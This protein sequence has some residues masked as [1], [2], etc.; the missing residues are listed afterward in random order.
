[1]RTSI[2]LILAA[3]AFSGCASSQPS[4]PGPATA[5]A[6]AQPE[7]PHAQGMTGG[8]MNGEM[9]GGDMAAMCPME[10]K[11]TTAGAEDVDGG[12][13]MVFKTTGDVAELRQRVAHM[14]EMH[15][16]HHGEG[17]GPGMGMQGGQAG[18]GG[19]EQSAHAGM[20]AGMMM[21]PSTAR[22][23]DVDGGARLILAPKDPADLNKV[24]QHVQQHAQQMASGKCPMM[25]MPASQ[26]TG[27]PG[28]P[29]DH[30]AHH[31]GGTN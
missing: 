18:A 28:E 8:M 9:M 23:E 29:S 25:S 12:A 15:N 4:G 22:A 19:A 7:A 11:G 26:G 21:P 20:M 27:A 2:L 5:S 13:A 14:A 31:P 16:Q 17:H 1:M 10:V 24:R 3:L 6:Q 30:A